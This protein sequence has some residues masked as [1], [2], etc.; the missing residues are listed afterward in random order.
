MKVNIIGE[1]IYQ[2]PIRFY[3]KNISAYGII[4]FV[5]LSLAI[6]VLARGRRLF[7]E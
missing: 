2:Y 3:L 5:I 4:L 6:D 1:Y 7:S